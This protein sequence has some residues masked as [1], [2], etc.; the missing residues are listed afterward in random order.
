M[1]PYIYSPILTVVNDGQFYSVEYKVWDKGVADIES[2]S[3]RTYNEAFDFF[4]TIP[5]SYYYV[6]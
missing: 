2:V 6:R 1:K 3:F 5:M 4:N